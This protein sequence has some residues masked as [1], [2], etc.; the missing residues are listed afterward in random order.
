M[1]IFPNKI[2]FNNSEIS[3]N[4]F[5]STV[6]WAWDKLYRTCFIKK[7][8][9][10]FQEQRTTNDALF[11][12]SAL[13]LAEKISVLDKNKKLVHHRVNNLSSLENTRHKSWMCFYNMLIALK[14]R[15]IKENKFN[16]L[17]RDFVNYALHFSLW[18]F[19]TLPEPIHSLLKEK[20]QNEWFHSLGI[21]SKKEN[22]FEN[23]KEYQQMLEI[24][25]SCKATTQ[26]PLLFKDIG[27]G[28]KTWCSPKSTNENNGIKKYT[29]DLSDNIYTRYVSWDPIKEG[30]CD[31]EIIRL[32]AVEKRTKKIVEFPVN[33]IVSNGKILGNK[34]EFRNQKGCWI[35][36]T[37]EGAYES[38]TVEAKIKNI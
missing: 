9:L 24:M 33:K 11:V 16:E 14:E 6:G 30:S 21:T 38:F 27:F 35:G 4:I 22:Y 15:L 13:F 12:F 25:K 7:H 5:L 26:S 34:V 23:K 36:C 17:E 18:N 37:V 29:Y 20:L 31:V 10:K 28:C 1:I 8:D 3:C 19:N 2:S 32:Y